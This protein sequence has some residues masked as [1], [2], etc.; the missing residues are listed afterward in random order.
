[1]HK[2]AYTVAHVYIVIIYCS[3]KYQS[4]NLSPQQIPISRPVAKPTTT[5]TTEVVVIPPRPP[6][7]S[8]DICCSMKGVGDTATELASQ[9]LNH[10]ISIPAL[11]KL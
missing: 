3:P 4:F 6:S 9:S 1:M 10:W 11:G 8:A 7:D 5:P 2:K